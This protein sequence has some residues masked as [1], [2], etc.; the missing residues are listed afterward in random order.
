M[1]QAA[2]GQGAGKSG[3]TRRALEARNLLTV[4]DAIV[5]AALGREESRGAHSRLDFPERAEVARHSLVRRGQL[6]FSDQL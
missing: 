1:R 5:Q 3:L 2:V 4:A 6:R